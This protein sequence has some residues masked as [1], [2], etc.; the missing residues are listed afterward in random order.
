[1]MRDGQIRVYKPD[2]SSGTEETIKRQEAR[3]PADPKI[4]P[5]SRCE[6]ATHRRSGLRSP[7]R[8]C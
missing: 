6:A 7:A 1:M 2:G 5:M 8:S 4:L 3:L